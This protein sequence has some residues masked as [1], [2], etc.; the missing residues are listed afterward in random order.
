[1][2]KKAQRHVKFF[3]EDI[4]ESI[5]RAEFILQQTTEK[6]F[7]HDWQKQDIVIRRLSIIGE[8]AKH[9]PAEIRHKFPQIAFR[10]MAALRDVVIHDYFGLHYQII[11]NIVTIELPPSKPFL[12]ELITYLETKEK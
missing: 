5:E 7:M 4:I 11:W 12:R 3:V 2:T 1:M 6:D 9:I 10:Q 8:A